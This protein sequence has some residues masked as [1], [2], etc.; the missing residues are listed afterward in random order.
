[1]REALARSGHA[2]LH[3]APHGR[4]HTS[5]PSETS[6]AHAHQP[7]RAYAQAL[8]F[9]SSSA[10]HADPA[11]SPR[12]GPAGSTVTGV[13]GWSRAAAGQEAALGGVPVGSRRASRGCAGVGGSLHSETPGQNDG[14][15]ESQSQRQS[16]RVALRH[17]V[18]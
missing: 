3:A 8:A 4:G 15:N 16:E 12:V 14:Q 6:H 10:V 11:R 17:A 9:P 2:Q 13:C 5:T 1:M 18:F 7:Q